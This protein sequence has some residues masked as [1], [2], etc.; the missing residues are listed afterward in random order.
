MTINV[1]ESGGNV[2][3]VASG[4]VNTAG[5]GPG[6]DG[7]TWTAG[8]WGGFSLGSMIVVNTTADTPYNYHEG[9]SGPASFGSGNRFLADSGSG[10]IFGIRGNTLYLPKDYV[11]GSPLSS[12]STWDST[13]IADLG[14]TPG[15]YTYTWGSGANADSATL[16]IGVPNISVI[17]E[18]T[19]LLSLA[20]LLGGGLLL[21]RREKHSL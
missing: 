8:V 5:L 11:S 9:I 16:N 13:T 20:G 21:R 3:A 19:S 2:I 1:S 17:P 6:Q 10:T 14:L 4:M 15:S 18:P 7:G 12:T